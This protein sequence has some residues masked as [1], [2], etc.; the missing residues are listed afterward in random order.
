MSD[1]SIAIAMLV[2]VSLTLVVLWYQERRVNRQL[3]VDLFTL[4]Q[5]LDDTRRRRRPIEHAK[6]TFVERG[7]SNPRLPFMPDIDDIPQFRR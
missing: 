2:I 7:R 3:R 6:T 1:A 5:N 4:G